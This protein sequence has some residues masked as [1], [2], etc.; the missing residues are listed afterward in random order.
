VV[1]GAAAMLAISTGVFAQPPS[2]PA[3]PAPAA[4]PAPEPTPT[5]QDAIEAFK[6][7]DYTRAEELLKRQSGARPDDFVPLY[8]LACCRAMQNDAEGAVKYL[9]EAIEKGFCDGYQLRHDDTLA[10]V[11]KSPKFQA[12]L[13]AWPELLAAR[14]DANVAK[15]NL[16]F[17]DPK[18][19][20]ATDDVLRLAYRSAFN[21]KAFKEAREQLT[22]VARFADKNLFVD[23]LA[24]DQAKEDAWV[25]VV[26]PLRTDFLRWIV[27][28]YGPD[29]IGGNSTIGGAYEHDAKRLV[30]MDLGATL[31]HEFFHVLHWRDNTRRGQS[32]PIWIQEGLCSLIEDYDLDAAGNVQP[33]TSWRT[34]IAKRLENLRKL[35]PI[36][37]LAAMTPLKF[38]GQRP[39]ANY[40]QA[41]AVFLY[42]W[43]EGKLKEWYAHYVA[44]HHKDT[45]G[46]KSFEAVLGK[47]IKEI[48]LDYRR[49]LRDLPT[50]P[51]SIPEGAASLGVEVDSGAGEGPVVTSVN[52]TA[53]NFS[54]PK[55]ALS[56]SD[57]ITGIDGKATRDIAELVRVLSA[58]K[59]GD[60]VEVEYRRV[61]KFATTKVKLVPR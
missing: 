8:N 29:V 48:N 14:R 58:Y 25:V 12:I 10:P 34:N 22:R 13:N 16:L 31:R 32:H 43:Q 49:W 9:A 18:Y 6:A 59:V 60:E 17:K 24:P 41:R 51:E 4:S 52:R 53:R 61:K 36:E 1:V 27:S 5:T 19:T 42:L 47:P 44:N 28:I 3:S 57:I 33:S 21:E 11:R 2:T 37:T 50:V 30:S 54:D 20:N 46:I 15:A 40:A 35:M 38:T 26:L 23:I 45:T 7:G 56:R 39:L 55:T